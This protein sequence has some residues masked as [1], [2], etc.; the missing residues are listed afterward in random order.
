MSTAVHRSQINLGDLTPYLAYG[1]VGCRMTPLR[2]SS[3]D[4]S[5]S[6]LEG[7]QNAIPRP[8]SSTC[9]FLDTCRWCVAVSLRRRNFSNRDST[10]SSTLAARK[11]A[12]L[13]G[14]MHAYTD[15]KENEILII[16]KEIQMGSVAKSYMRKG[17]IICEE[18]CKY[19]TIYEE[20]VGHI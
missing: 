13:S 19:L 10:I 15:K 20:V 16:Y 14:M 4:S 2:L 17:L 11:S 18:M 12:R 3:I 9:I 5:H 7:R 1:L 8:H 6:V